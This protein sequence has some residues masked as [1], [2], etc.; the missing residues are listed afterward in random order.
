VTF[1]VDRLVWHRQELSGELLVRCDLLGTDA[2][3]D[4]LLSVARFNLSSARARNE[5]ASQLERQ[6]RASDIP[7]RPLIE[8]LCQRVLAAERAGD[9]AIVLRDVDRPDEDERTVRA[10]GFILPWQ[11]PAI[12]FGDGGACKSY[13]ALYLGGLLAAEGHRVALFDWELDAADHRERFGQLFGAEMPA[14]FLYT[15]CSRP[16]LYETDRLK[17]VVRT[18]GIEYGVFD[19]IGFACHEAPES[20]ES[21]LA[22]FRCVRQLGIGSLHIAHISKAEGGDQKPFGS[23]FFFNSARAVWNI[24]ATEDGAGSLTLGVFDRKPNLRARQQPFAIDVSFAPDRTTFKRTEIADVEA[25]A[26][27]ISLYQRIR[28]SLRAGARTRDELAEALGSKPE[29]LRRTIN[30]AIE[31]GHLVKF[32]GPGGVE[33]IGLPARAS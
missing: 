30:R 7:W 5:Y 26:P 28:A 4:G 3:D 1:E 12:V 20:A 18:Q 14:T 9:A 11:H 17:R 23:A 29:T 24:K 10:L 6:S 8:E 33:R 32:P 13:L 16:L 21:A 2:I 25:F 22:Y 19:S 27:Q 31:K 15:R